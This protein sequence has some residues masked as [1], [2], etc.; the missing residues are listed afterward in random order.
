MKLVNR[1]LEI[2]KKNIFFVKIALRFSSL[3]SRKLAIAD[4]HLERYGN[5]K[6]NF[7]S[8]MDHYGFVCM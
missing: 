2:L 5:I 3:Y 4:G 7:N 8:G 6:G 1:V